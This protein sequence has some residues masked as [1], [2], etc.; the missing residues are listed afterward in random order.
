MSKAN[1]KT[2][3]KTSHGVW[4][5]ILESPVQ[6]WRSRLSWR[7]ALAVFLTILTVQAGILSLTI[8]DYEQAR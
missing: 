3:D 8:R 6:I 4:G 5:P 2:K 7:I 1:K